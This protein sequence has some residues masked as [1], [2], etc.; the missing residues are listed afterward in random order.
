M[1]K[2]FVVV[3]MI[4]FSQFAFSQKRIANE[5]FSA[6]KVNVTFS[7]DFIEKLEPLRSYV[8]GYYFEGQGPDRMKALIVH[9]S[10]MTFKYMTEEQLSI[11]VLPPDV[12]GKKVKYDEYGY[13][14]AYVTK[15]MDL[16]PSKFFFK[17]SVNYESMGLKHYYFVDSLLAPGQSVED[18]EKNYLIPRISITWDVYDK[19][20]QV[21]IYT[22]SSNAVSKKPIPITKCLM[23]GYLPPK[24][25]GVTKCDTETLYEILELAITDLIVNVLAEL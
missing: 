20:G 2:L 12:M 1:K 13:P 16:Q 11:A 18:I 3:F 4:S 6:F 10:F 7:T 24:Y 21:P 14:D 22:F 19:N 25:T 9:N 8:E 15:A 5:D 23:Q 17:L